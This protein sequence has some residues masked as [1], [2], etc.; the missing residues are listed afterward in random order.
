MRVLVTGA[1]GLLGSHT[2]RELKA[3]GYQVRA[4]VRSRHKAERLFAGS[5]EVVVG[6]VTDP[7]SVARAL[8]GVEGVV[9]C[10]AVV[11]TSARRAREVTD[12][13]LRGVEFV[14]GGAAVRGIERVVYLSSLAALFVPGQ[15][16][17]VD[18][19]AV[20]PRGAYARSKIDSERFVRSLQDGGAGIC[21]LYPP[22]LIGPDDPGLSECNHAV[23]ALLTQLVFDTTTGL[24]AIDA[25]DLARVI[26]ALLGAG[27]R[28]RH[29]VAGRYSR[30]PELIALLDE[31]TARRIRRMRVSGSL[32]RGVGRLADY[33]N[34]VVPFD[35]PLSSESMAYATQWYPARASPAV[36]ATG[37]QMRTARVTYAD[38]IRWLY[39]AGHI[40]ATQGGRLACPT[41]GR[42][43]RRR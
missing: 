16:F 20:A 11:S 2:V 24:E 37:V 19:L 42:P 34:H 18:R 30:W 17:D 8:G 21:V 39:E 22:G 25:R 31:L 23:R 38:T 7:E 41:L 28:G 3:A 13:N 9:H 15:P 1:T 36:R 27:E 32:L 40:T 5:V 14:I 10:A 6:D 26:V 35:F 33:V 12:T 4:L 43:S 29:I